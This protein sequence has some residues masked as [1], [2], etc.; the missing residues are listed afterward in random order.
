MPEGDYI[1]GA[2]GGTVDA[3]RVAWVLA[4]LALIVVAAST[5]VL[6]VATASDRTNAERLHKEGVAVQ[7]TVTG[8]EGISS[9]VGMG[10]EYYDCR[11]SY[12]LDGV[13]VE[14]ALIHGSRSDRPPG[15]VVQAR[16]VPGDPGSLALDGTGGQS[17][18]W[19]APIVLGAVAVAGAMALGVVAKRS[20]R[21]GA[22]I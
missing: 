1:R 11:G 4:V 15:Q 21:R 10:I 19:V 7:V 16:A 8:C 13:P 6:A 5:V 2:R 9:G 14:G 18:S 12:V 3:R 20:S 22:A 17:T